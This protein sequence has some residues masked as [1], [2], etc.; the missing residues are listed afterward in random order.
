MQR[1]NILITGRVQGVGFRFYVKEKAIRLG[2]TGFVRN[3]EEDKVEVI[4][5]GP[6]ELLHELV[7]LCRIGPS[8]AYISNF[9]VKYGGFTGEYKKF[10]AKF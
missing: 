5:E 4:A 10:S 8:L 2:I 7:K 3:L 9:D 1:V 6:E